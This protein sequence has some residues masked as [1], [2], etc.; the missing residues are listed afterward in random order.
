MIAITTSQETARM[1]GSNRFSLLLCLIAGAVA[2]EPGAGSNPIANPIANPGPESESSNRFRLYVADD[3]VIRV[4]HF[5]LG[6]HGLSAPVASRS[7]SLSHAGQPVPLHVDDGGDGQ[8][9]PGDSMTFI[10]RA[11]VESDA[12]VRPGAGEAVHVLWTAAPSPGARMQLRQVET[13]T[14][15]QAS[16]PLRRRMRFESNLLRL[17]VDGRTGLYEDES[18]WLWQSMNHLASLP[19]RIPLV[20]LSADRVDAGP[21]Q[22]RIR[23]RG[24]SDAASSAALEM[25]DHVVEVAL[26]GKPLGTVSASGRGPFLFEAGDL[27]TSALLDADNVLELRVPARLPEGGDAALIDVVHLDWIEIEF[28]LIPVNAV[29]AGRVLS[30]ERQGLPWGPSGVA[31]TIYSEAGRRVDVPASEAASWV[32]VEDGGLWVVSERGYRA[33]SAIEP[34]RVSN[35]RDRRDPVDYFVIAPSRLLA[36]V[37]PLTDHHTRRGRLI[38]S[39]A[40]QDI[41][42]EFNHGQAHPRAVRD[43]LAH[44]HRTRAVPA[45]RFVLLVG[46]ADWWSAGAPPAARS[47]GGDRNGVPTW[48]IR[49]RDGPVASDLPFV[50]FGDDPWV[51]MMAIGRFPASTIDE[52]RAMVEKSVAY[53]ESPPAGSWRD[54]VILASERSRSMDARNERLAK[55]ADEQG[56]T[57]ELRTAGPGNASEA[58]D[59]LRRTF[60]DGAVLVHFFGHGGRFMWQMGAGR[61]GLGPD[62]FAMDDLDRLAPNRRLPVVLSLS[63]NT[64]PFDHPSA[65]S[66]AEKMLRLPDRGA[67]AVVAASARNSPL[68]RFSEA[69]VDEMLSG[70]TV[71]EAMMRAKAVGPHPDIAY[72]YNLFGDPALV[73]AGRD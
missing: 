3:A 15:N 35:L 30:S 59:A 46:D 26:N 2:A 67:V 9:G 31:V 24:G 40:L 58:R 13:P 8:F 29:D 34:A 17:P 70:L 19:T 25:P 49:S 10:A 7:L 22:L 43:F 41:Y 60:D 42:D 39:I 5:T 1:G 52:A 11:T 66:L 16:A 23:F 20:G 44:A 62:L 54:R 4:D 27:P 51:P 61:G 32:P 68:V 53:L 45:P 28:P 64:G 71:G 57:P 33:P 38:E 50:N 73:V 55:L 47:E 12:N 65:D 6:K 69:L 14:E 37:A 48:Q 18:L 63:C 36:A 21:I 72:F 56:R